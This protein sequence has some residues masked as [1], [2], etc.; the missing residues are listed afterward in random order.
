MCRQLARVEWLPVCVLRENEERCD[1]LVRVASRSLTAL[2]ENVRLGQSR[3]ARVSVG[4]EGAIAVKLCT[5]YELADAFGDRALD[6]L[7]AKGLLDC[8]GNTLHCDQQRFPEELHSALR[9]LVRVVRGGTQT[10]AGHRAIRTG[11]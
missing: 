10:V 4:S 1:E 11:I 9:C 5:L 6:F 8:L 7:L 2:V 3:V